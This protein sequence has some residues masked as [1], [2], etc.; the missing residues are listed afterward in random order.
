MKIVVSFLWGEINIYTFYDWSRNIQKDVYGIH[1]RT[2][3]KKCG[4]GVASRN[5]N[6]TPQKIYQ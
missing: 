1:R 5:P 2:S 3:G 4:I 6:V